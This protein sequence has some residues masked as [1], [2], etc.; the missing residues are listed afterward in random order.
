VKPDELAL[1]LAPPP[2]LL[3]LLPASYAGYATA[4]TVKPDD[5]DV[6]LTEPLQ[7][8][9]AHAGTT[10]TAAA[11][12]TSKRGTKADLRCFLLAMASSFRQ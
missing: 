2:L 5:A 9:T 1:L 7:D 10:L 4:A 8:A 6:V 11:A 12:G 3:L